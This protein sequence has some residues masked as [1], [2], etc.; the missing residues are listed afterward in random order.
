[1]GGLYLDS[2]LDY[3]RQSQNADGGWGY[4]PGK[5]SWMEPTTYAMLALHRTP[6][7][8]DRVA[9]AWKLVRSWQ[10]ADGS[11]RPS[12]QVHG[13]TWVTAH[14]V[15]LATVQGVYDEDVRRSVDWLL[16]VSGAEHSL[17]MRFAAHFNLLRTM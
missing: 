11:T 14:V 12:G 6:G 5:Q 10:T 1:M 7:A 2:R 9:K 17:G 13:G 16:R 8:E 15:T 3:L 4:F